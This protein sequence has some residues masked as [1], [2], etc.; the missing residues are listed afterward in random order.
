MTFRTVIKKKTKLIPSHQITK[1]NRY[2][3]YR[4]FFTKK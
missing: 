4:I 3:S 2:V 1:G